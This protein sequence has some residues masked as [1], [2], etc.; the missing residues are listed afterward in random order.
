MMRD[1][2]ACITLTAGRGYAGLHSCILCPTIIFLVLFLRKEV[3]AEK[4]MLG[5]AREIMLR[6]SNRTRIMLI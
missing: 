3:F 4:L 6:S 2:L 5:F 1:N